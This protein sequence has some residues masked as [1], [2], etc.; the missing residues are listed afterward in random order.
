MFTNV[1]VALRQC[2]RCIRDVPTQNTANS[3]ADEIVTGAGND[4][5]RGAALS[6][7]F[8]ELGSTVGWVLFGSVQFITLTVIYID[9]RVRKEAY[10]LE[11]MAAQLGN[12]GEPSI[13]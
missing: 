7:V 3:T 8:S 13:P 10:D 9:L 6:Q 1:A 4:S 11:L 2:A 12:S 5:V